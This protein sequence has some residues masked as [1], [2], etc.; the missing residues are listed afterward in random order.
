MRRSVKVTCGVDSEREKATV[1]PRR[2]LRERPLL[3]EGESESRRNAAT[4]SGASCRPSADGPCAPTGT[5][6][7][8]RHS[9]VMRSS[10]TCQ[11]S[12]TDQT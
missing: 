8:L 3:R 4:R 1:E 2:A 6:N 9:A 10:N 7:K 12:A 5:H 11:P